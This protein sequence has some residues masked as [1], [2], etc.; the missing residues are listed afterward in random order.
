MS[1]QAASSSRP[2][3]VMGALI[4]CRGITSRIEAGCAKAD[5][6]RSRPAETRKP[7]TCLLMLRAVARRACA[8]GHDLVMDACDAPI[9]VSMTT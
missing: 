2:S 1:F 9:S 4:R 8:E 6:G 5:A 3:R 7:G